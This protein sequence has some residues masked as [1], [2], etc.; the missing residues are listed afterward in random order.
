MT[1][2]NWDGD[3]ESA[4]FK[5]RFDDESGN[6][7]LAE[8]DTGTALFEWDGSE[9]Q[10]RGPVE[11]NDEDV[12]GIGSLTATS[13]NFDSVNTEGASIDE[14]VVSAINTSAQSIPDD[15]ETKLEL[16]YAE[17]GLSGWSDT[18]NE[19]VVPENGQYTF[20]GGVVFNNDSG[21]GAGDDVIIRLRRDGSAITGGRD[22][23]YKSN[24]STESFPVSGIPAIELSENDTI[25]ISVQ[26]NSGSEQSLVN[27]ARRSRLI[28]SKVG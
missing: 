20:N 25:H 4:P 18:E 23:Y 26:Q 15:T 14:A 12:S 17:G 3:A 2:I 28:I 8:T 1:N 6:L 9:W 27:D 5:S 16:E 22:E 11:M 10:F 24:T 7:I 13:G 21:W 19:F